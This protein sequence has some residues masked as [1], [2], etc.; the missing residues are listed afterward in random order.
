MQTN[1][2][3]MWIWKSLHLGQEHR[4]SISTGEFSHT[5]VGRYNEVYNWFA[6]LSLQNGSINHCKQNYGST[7]L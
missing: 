6:I 3:V 7:A 4:R 2:K 1:S 5:Q